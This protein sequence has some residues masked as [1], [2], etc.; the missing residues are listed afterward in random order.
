MKRDSEISR[1]ESILK[2][3][4]ASYRIMCNAHAQLVEREVTHVRAE[5]DLKGALYE[6]FMRSND[7]E[8]RRVAAKA[9]GIKMPRRPKPR[10]TS[11]C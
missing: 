9:L 11:G 1:L 10:I 2:D 3:T 8:S 4:E 6:I 7:E 5:A